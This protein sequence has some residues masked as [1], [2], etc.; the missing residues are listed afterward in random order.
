MYLFR[1]TA[2]S[3][4][5]R[6]NPE[7]KA[8]LADLMCHRLATA[9]KCYRL[10]EHEKT[11]VA[12][13]CHLSSTMKLKSTHS[14]GQSEPTPPIQSETQSEI[15]SEEKSSALQKVVW[16][17]SLTSR[18]QDVF[19]QKITTHHAP[20]DVVREKLKS[21]DDLPHLNPRKVYDKLCAIMNSC[22]HSVPPPLPLA[23]PNECETATD[24]LSHMSANREADVIC[25]YITL[26]HY[27]YY[28]FGGALIIT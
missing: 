24:R 3:A 11:S 13:A 1:K 9:S 18:L 8:N 25:L 14:E 28:N 23:L 5:T 10:V 17:K 7:M 6:K 2:V 21:Y 16:N 15:F 4:I 27:S 26:W 22:T 12:A 20:L 19:T